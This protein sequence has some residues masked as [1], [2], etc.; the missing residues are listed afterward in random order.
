V[1]TPG[2]FFSFL[3]RLFL[4]GLR[5][6]GE[7][8]WPGSTSNLNSYLVGGRAKLLEIIDS[9]ASENP[10]NDKQKRPLKLSDGAGPNFATVTFAYR[11]NEPV[12]KP[13]ELL[14]PSRARSSAPCRPLRRRQIHRAGR[15]W[16]AAFIEVGRRRYSD[17]RAGRI[18]NVPHEKS[19]RQTGPPMSGTGRLS[20]S[21]TP[22]RENIAFG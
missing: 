12:L 22:S 10:M 4:L 8:A 2:Q 13:H 7:N 17:R 1:L 14:T 18:A 9:P 3:S 16:P 15:C 21:A 11:P 19:L 5:A 20:L 6:A